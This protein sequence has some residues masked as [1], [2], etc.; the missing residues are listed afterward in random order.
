MNRIIALDVETTGLSSGRGD[1][2]IEIGAVVVEGG[3][4]V[5]EFT[6]LIRT[7]HPIHWAAQKVHG[8]S[9]AMLRNSPVPGVVWPE[10]ARFIGSSP[11]L[12]HNARFDLPFLQHEFS[13]L[14]LSLPNPHHCTLELSRRR[15][16]H[17]PNHRL[18][19]VARHLLGELPEDCR[20]H[21]ALADARL[22]AQVWLV[23]K[24]ILQA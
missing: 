19:T 11:L 5:D 6:S 7:G 3:V 18:E 23:M 1:R 9:D 17:L 22:A 12:A 21:R 8:I 4:L 10:F 24:K 14:G 15:L 20:L 13:R 2:V 16:P